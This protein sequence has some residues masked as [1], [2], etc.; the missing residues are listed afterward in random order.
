MYYYT[1]AV[2][3]HLPT[4]KILCDSI[5]QA[6]MTE[7]EEPAVALKN[8]EGVYF[9]YGMH[10]GVRQEQPE[11]D[12]Y[13]HKPTNT[14]LLPSGQTGTSVNNGDNSAK[15]KKKKAKRRP[16]DATINDPNAEY[17]SSRVIKQAPNGDVIVESLEDEHDDHHD[18]LSASIWDNLTV[19]E[20]EELKRFWESLEEPEK[21]KLVK[22]DKK[23]ILDLFRTFSLN[24]DG[25]QNSHHN[26]GA[27]ASTLAG[28]PHHGCT[29]NSCGRQSSIIEAE[30]EMIYDNHFD[31]IIDFIH[32]VRDIKD[33]NAL[34]GLLFGGFHMLEEEHR[35]K[36][37][38]ARRANNVPPPRITANASEIEHHNEQHPIASPEES[39]VPSGSSEVTNAA[40]SPSLAEL[41]E[42]FRDENP[43]ADWNLCAQLL[44]EFRANGNTEIDKDAFIKNFGNILSSG[45]SDISKIPEN[46]AS[47]ISKVAEDFLN[48]DGKTF[49]EMVEAL[50]GSRSERAD[51]LRTLEEA[52]ANGTSSDL[53]QP[54]IDEQ[55][56]LD[57][58]GEQYI[59]G[60]LA[61]LDGYVK[62]NLEEEYDYDTYDDP[63]YDDPE[64]DEQLSD[65]E[66]EISE[67]E[68]MQ[69]IR[70]LFLIQVIKLFQER[71]KNAYKEKLS[72]DRTR[73]L[74]EELEA[75]E[76]AK[77]KKE[78][79]K[80]KQ[81]EKAKEKKRL[82]Q[83]AKDEERKRKEEEEKAREEE[84]RQK[85]E[86]LRAEQKRRKEEARQKKEEEK[87]KRIEEL[88]LKKEAELKR[89]EEKEK[90]EREKKALKQESKVESAA[91]PIEE[92]KEILNAVPEDDPTAELQN[93]ILSG[94]EQLSIDES[95]APVQPLPQLAPQLPSQLPSQIAPQL[96]TPLSTP[97]S[98]QLPAQ[99][100]HS[101]HIPSHHSQTTPFLNE[102]EM[103]SPVVSQ[104]TATHAPASRG[105][106]WSQSTVNSNFTPFHDGGWN[107]RNSSIWGNG[108]SSNIWSSQT[109][110]L[111]GNSMNMCFHPGMANMPGLP[112]G[113]EAS[114]NSSDAIPLAGANTM[115]P[116]MS[117]PIPQSSTFSTTIEN[118]TVRSAAY[119]AF[120]MMQNASQLEFG[121][122]SAV[123]LYQ[124]AK[125]I[126]ATDVSYSQFLGL[127][128]DE[129]DSSY[130][131]DYVYDD[132]GAVSHIK[133]SVK[134]SL[135]N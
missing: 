10:P 70:R 89:Q 16:I 109:P 123:K 132:Y 47:G 39:L 68:K 53:Q 126:M 55:F 24:Q 120:T 110:T 34:P 32:E 83:L 87:R 116:S 94:L 124:T 57:Q 4:P 62:D 14:T 38:R 3:H 56:S 26:S 58:V 35:M 95:S 52:Q 129:N 1:L 61:Q 15:K 82:Q 76:N 42:K 99:L 22:I 46:F 84:L 85:Q 135:W 50:S 71:L 20:Q 112:N 91:K 133:A 93:A 51:T 101:S 64:Y 88:R 23:L 75:E 33:L 54:S 28:T 117:V 2:L 41:L 108:A 130:R 73:I 67:E 5:L 72:Q 80:L 43:N 77:K 8:G 37:S 29:C 17:P 13:L 11:A 63:E 49:V 7:H 60:R 30:L 107:S 65:T 90:R 121:L 111:G 114:I 96:S 100:P 106:L 74:I 19:E 102:M 104:A 40:G 59:N 119:Q 31:D 6:Y 27:A 105:L 125:M 134:S 36:K 21:V 9:D 86:E 118:E 97:L 127:C 78:L 81:K 79:K 128:R 131:F 69:E 12:S 66:S 25:S 18:N 44:Q 122:A 113:L 115:S 98:T 48:N 103:Q 45:G 92:T